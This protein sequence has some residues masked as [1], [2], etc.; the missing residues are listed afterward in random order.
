MIN[1]LF[2]LVLCVKVIVCLLSVFWLFQTEALVLAH[3]TFV[4]LVSVYTFKNI[5]QDDIETNYLIL[6]SNVSRIKIRN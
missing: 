5:L 3:I 4:L 2:L 6:T 1:A